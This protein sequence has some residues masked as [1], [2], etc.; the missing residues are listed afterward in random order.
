MWEK[1]RL[2]ALIWFCQKA[3]HYI[4]I[5]TMDSENADRQWKAMDVVLKWRDATSAI[6]ST[7]RMQEHAL[8]TLCSIDSFLSYGTRAMF[9]HWHH[10]IQVI[11]YVIDGCCALLG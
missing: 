11:V 9:I 1:K 7:T 8:V 6:P 4:C 2:S 5:W 3:G 10:V